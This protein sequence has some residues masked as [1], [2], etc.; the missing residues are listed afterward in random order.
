[1]T[2]HKQR[3]LN[4][5]AFVV[6]R[7][8]SMDRL[9]AQVDKVVQNQ[10]Q[11]LADL[12]DSTGQETH[13]SIY[14]FGNATQCAIYD[15][16]VKRLVGANPLASWY[17]G[18]MT[19]LID[20]TMTSQEELARIPEL[21]CDHAF[22]TFVLTDGGENASASTPR[23]RGIYNAARELPDQLAKM[24]GSQADNWTVAVLVPNI[25]CK[26]EAIKYGFPKDN[27]MI[28]DV[29]AQGLAEAERE[30]H[31]ATQSF[32]TARSTG[33]R[34][35]KALFSTVTANTVT[36]AQVD[37]SSLKPVDPSDF[38]IIPVALSSSS[39]LEIKIPAKSKTLK[40]PE[41]IKHVEI[42]PFVEETGRAYV[43]G[44]AYYR[45]TKSEKYHYGKGIALVHRTTRKV[46]RGPE[47]EKLIGL[48]QATTRIKPPAA[49]DEYEVYVRSTSFNRQIEVGGSVLLF[50]K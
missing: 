35:S 30:I 24:L 28:W 17:D 21:H 27:I 6:D 46:Y 2:N 10:I 48:D 43:T 14:I 19:A 8:G 29:S 47:C 7:S 5:V 38:M 23:G 4:H 50:N 34:G 12:D 39:K 13:V 42:Q 16:D 25:L 22:L 26:Q 18:G 3:L 9:N 11:R 20:A 33:T 40:N 15:T 36:Q 44:N 45:L 41:G 1:M 31:Q 32:Y 49:T 37:A